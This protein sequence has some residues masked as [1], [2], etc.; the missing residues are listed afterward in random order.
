MSTRFAARALQCTFRTVEHLHHSES[1]MSRSGAE[2]PHRFLRR[3][4]MRERE[5]APFRPLVQCSWTYQHE[6][7]ITAARSNGSP[8]VGACQSVRVL[9]LIIFLRLVP[10]FLFFLPD[11][12]ISRCNLPLFAPTVSCLSLSS[13][14]HISHPHSKLGIGTYIATTRKLPSFPR[15]TGGSHESERGEESRCRAARVLH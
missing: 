14:V 1:M 9:Y 10:L 5:A 15:T 4:L 6:R 13:Y 2:D 3:D 11:T 12:R 7:R 8:R